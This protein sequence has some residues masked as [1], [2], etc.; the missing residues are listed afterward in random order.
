MLFLVIK[1]KGEV[2]F[3]WQVGQLASFII[4]MITKKNPVLLMNKD[5]ISKSTL[6]TWTN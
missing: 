4:I 2:V 3:S 5:F 1:C 6:K